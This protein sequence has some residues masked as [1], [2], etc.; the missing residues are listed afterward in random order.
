MGALPSSVH[1]TD[2]ALG[3]SRSDRC[4]IQSSTVR[5]PSIEVQIRDRSGSLRALIRRSPGQLVMR[6]MTVEVV[7]EF[8]QLSFEI[9]GRPE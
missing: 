8:E 6:A 5:L 4:L 9:E 1:Q 2:E 7:S 3:Q